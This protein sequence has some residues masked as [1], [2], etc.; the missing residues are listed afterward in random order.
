MN[1]GFDASGCTIHGIFLEMFMIDGAGYLDG[2]KNAK[3]RHSLP[4]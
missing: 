2:G 1:F 4:K 3:M